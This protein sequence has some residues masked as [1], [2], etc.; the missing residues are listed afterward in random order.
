LLPFILLL[1]LCGK[2]SADCGPFLRC[3]RRVRCKPNSRREQ[4]RREKRQT[5]FI[6]HGKASFCINWRNPALVYPRLNWLPR[7]QPNHIDPN[8]LCQIPDIVV[9]FL[10]VCHATEARIDPLQVAWDIPLT[11][12]NDTAPIS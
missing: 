2:I 12:L 3:T 8:Q 5:R 9:P 10:S 1:L 6:A 11:N 4:A 7:S